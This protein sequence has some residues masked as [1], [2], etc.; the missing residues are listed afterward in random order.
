MA[1]SPPESPLML[2]PVGL[3]FQ[4]HMGVGRHSY[5][6]EMCDDPPPE[7]SFPPAS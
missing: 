1:R 2:A 5:P 7:K 6:S 3:W 4:E